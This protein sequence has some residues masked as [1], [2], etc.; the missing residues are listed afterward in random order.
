MKKTYFF[1]VL[2]YIIGLL[3]LACDGRVIA[4]FNHFCMK[5]MVT[6]AGVKG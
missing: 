2:F 5:K 3:V 4:V 6:V 1:R